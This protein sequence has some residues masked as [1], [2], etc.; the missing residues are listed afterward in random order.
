MR[1]VVQRVRSAQVS[2]EGEVACQMDEGLLALVGVGQGDTA[3]SAAALAQRMVHLRI[4]GDE[5]GRM[6][7]SL[8]DTGGTLGVVSQFTLYG[9]ARHGRRPSFV[10]ACPAEEAAP[11]I[12]A[13]VDSARALGVRVVTGRFQAAMEVSLVNSGPVTI[14]L[15]TEKL[16]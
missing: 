16:F 2:V 6:N 10:A 8:L 13:V 9:D 12:E 3:E 11:L 15:D 7:L 4:F 1:A 14:L 5:S